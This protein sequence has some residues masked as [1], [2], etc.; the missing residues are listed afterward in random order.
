MEK[1]AILFADICGSTALYE[2]LGDDTARRLI[3][4]CIDTMVNRIPA[5]Q[6]TLVKTIG[7]EIMATFPDAESAFHAACAMQADVEN[8]SR[9]DGTTMQIRIG[10]NYG[11]VIR[12]ADDVFGNAVNV[13]AR[14]AAITR[15]GQ[16]MATQAVFDALPAGLQEKM[17]HI[18]RAEFKGKQEGLEIYQLIFRQE[19]ML[20]TRSGMPSNRKSPGN[21]D[22]MTLR[23]RDRSLKVNKERRSVALGRGEACDIPVQSDFASR[24]HSHIEL[25]SGKFMLV[26]QSTNGTF[27]RFSDGSEQHVIREELILRGSGMISLGRSFDD[28]REAYIEFS[29]TS[30]HAAPGIVHDV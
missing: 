22:E 15:A 7:D 20:I 3:S 14:V 26:D 23:Y 21:N 4:R 11:E 10:F 29:V 25:R 30:T 16:I 2:K 5:C 8:D 6:G 17:R 9:Q 18:L 28:G 1:L 12:E 19:D 13:A 27:V 24:L